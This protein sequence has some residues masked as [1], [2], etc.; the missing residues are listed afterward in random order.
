MVASMAVLTAE[1][2]AA[3]TAVPKAAY[4]AVRSAENLAAPRVVLLVEHSV[5]R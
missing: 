4:S 3:S 2:W 5:E 1:N